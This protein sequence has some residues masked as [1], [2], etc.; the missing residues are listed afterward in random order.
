MDK[1]TDKSFFFKITAIT[2]YNGDVV[3]QFNWEQLTWELRKKYDWYFKYRAAL[4][5]VK[6][7]KYEI[8]VTWGN[9]PAKDKTL[10]AIIK[11]KLIS[12]KRKLTEYKNK[13]RKAESEWDSI[14]PIEDDFMYKRCKSRINYLECELE[15]TK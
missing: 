7:P 3:E 11:N 15:I 9:E 10:E 14:F 1:V 2:K 6:Y 5:Q 8:L 4:L 12:K 13:L